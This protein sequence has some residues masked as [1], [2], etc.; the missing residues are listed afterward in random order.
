MRLKKLLY[1]RVFIEGQMLPVNYHKGS[2][3]STQIS[4]NLFQSFQFE[5]EQKT[6]VVMKAMRKKLNIF[7]FQLSIYYILEQEILIGANVDIAKTM[8]EKQIVFVIDREVDAILIP[9]AKIPEHKESISPS[10]FYGHLP[11]SQSQVLALSTQQMRSSVGESKV[12]S[13]LFLVL[14]R[15]NEKGR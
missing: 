8:K 5:P 1:K 10:S 12:L 6:C 11:D 14:I 4:G 15:W 7:M 9:S 3:S 2:Q 13:L